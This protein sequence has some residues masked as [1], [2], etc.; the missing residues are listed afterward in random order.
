MDLGEE[1]GMRSVGVIPARMASTRFPGK[2][3]A[4]IAGRPMLA[5]CHD[6]SAKSELLD[7][8]VIATCDQEIVDWASGEGIRAVMTS[9]KHERA[10][11]R[12]AEAVESLEADA[13]VLIQGDEPLVTPTMIDAALRPVVDGETECTNLAKRIETEEEFDSPN[14]VKLVVDLAGNALYMGRSRIPTTLHLGWDGI[15]AYKQVAIFGFTRERLFEFAALEPTPLE[16]AES[17]DMMRYIEHGRPIRI[18]FNDE[19]THA[20]DVPEDIPLVERMLA[21]QA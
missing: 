18:V 11:D 8:V 6:G 16:K 2:P 17:V 21:A 4:M 14:T 12:V 9:D 1:A 3:L 10:T 5:W 20:V 15:A 19:K 13:V 7:E